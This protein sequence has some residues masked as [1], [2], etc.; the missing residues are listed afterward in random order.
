MFW[1]LVLL[2]SCAPGM[3]DNTN[4]DAAGIDL[5][6][7]TGPEGECEPNIR[8]HGTRVSEYASPRLGETWTLHM[9][10]DNSLVQGPS[11]LQVEPSGLADIDN[12]SDTLTWVSTGS[13]TISLQ[14]GS[15][16][17]EEEVEVLD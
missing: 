13:G 15:I 12:F 8:V 5:P 2:V 1:T 6:V 14:T 7:D 11:V 4:D 3:A 17:S 10:C 9:W 16:Q